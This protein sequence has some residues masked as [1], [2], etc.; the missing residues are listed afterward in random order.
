MLL[1][2]GLGA[3]V[4]LCGILC[5][6]VQLYVSIRT[7]ESRRDVAGDPW[8]GRTLEWA[9]SSPPPAYNFAVLPRVRTVDAFWEMKQRGSH[10]A[11]AA[12]YE[13]IEMP[14]NTPTGF[15]ISFFAVVAGFGL[16]WHI[17]WMA[18][19]GLLGAAITMLALGWSDDREHEIPANEVAR[20]ER[21]RLGLGGAA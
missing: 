12:A 5:Q 1:A 4:I 9:T 21:S 8:N 18:I 11:A 19:L 6:I 10:P 17:W 20:L 7:R 3:A 16:I 2:A 13:P 15:I 14:R